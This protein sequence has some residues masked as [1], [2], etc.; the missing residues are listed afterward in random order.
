MLQ[1]IGRAGV[2]VGVEPGG[3]LEREVRYGNHPSAECFGDEAKAEAMVD[4]LKG[5]AVMYCIIWE[6][7]GASRAYEYHQWE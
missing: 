6:K 4:V 1:E 5:R 2:P 3:N 7:Q